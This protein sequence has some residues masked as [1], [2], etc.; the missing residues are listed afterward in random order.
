MDPISMMKKGAPVYANHFALHPPKISRSS[1]KD[2]VA[3]NKKHLQQVMNRLN[4]WSRKIVVCKGL[5]GWMIGNCFLNLQ[6]F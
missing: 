2:L 1:L 4:N 3:I 6:S 5:N